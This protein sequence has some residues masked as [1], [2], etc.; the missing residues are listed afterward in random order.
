MDPLL[1]ALGILAPELLPGGLAG[2]ILGDWPGSSSRLGAPCDDSFSTPAN[3]IPPSGAPVSVGL[4]QPPLLVKAFLIALKPKLTSEQNL[5]KVDQ[6]IFVALPPEKGVAWNVGE[7]YMNE[8]VYQYA[9]AIQGRR[10]GS[11]AFAKSGDL[12]QYIS[13]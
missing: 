11:I 1:F 3:D 7:E 12:V 5:G 4:Q 2:S 10:T 6:A 9:N 8:M 13:E